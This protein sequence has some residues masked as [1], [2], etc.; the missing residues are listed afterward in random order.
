[1]LVSR[2]TIYR[3][4][5]VQ[6]RGALK[7]ELTRHLRTGRTLRKPQRRPDRRLTRIRDMVNIGQRPPEVEDRAVPGHW[8]GD[9]IT[10]EQ[11]KT[12]IGTL[13][14]RA[15]GFVLL[16]HLPDDHGA[17]AVQK[18]MVEAE[19]AAR[20][21]A[22][23]S[24]LGPWHR[25]ANHAQIAAATDLDIYFCNP[26]HPGNGAATRT[27]TGSSGNT[28]P[29]APTCCSGAPASSTTSPQNSTTA[30]AN[31]SPGRPSRSTRPATVE[32]TRSIHRCHHRVN[33]PMEG[34]TH[35][36]R[37]HHHPRRPSGRLGFRCVGSSVTEPKGL[38]SR[39]A[40]DPATGR[41]CAR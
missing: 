24:D 14:E 7:R 32:P 40:V 25:E 20:N 12:A 1:M 34:V 6:G 27:P 33:P 23:D 8:E 11:N 15:T 22:P 16:L 21:A 17:A 28:S 10:A 41:P 35:L 30:P 3:A 5:Y 38:G 2:E 9:L 36:I 37:I 4:L 39:S 13:V 29:R 31:P 18:A 26:T 19:S